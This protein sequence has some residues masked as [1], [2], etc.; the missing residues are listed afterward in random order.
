MIARVRPT[1]GQVSLP[2]L[3]G[4]QDG[5]R[6]RSRRWLIGPVR[7]A[8]ADELGHDQAEE[9]RDQIGEKDHE[10]EK[11]KHRREDD[12]DVL[13]PSRPGSLLRWR[14]NSTSPWPS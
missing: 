12:A 1:E 10:R 7:P 5:A 8:S 13:A 6:G 3:L 11:P 4:R 9:C 2:S 14:S